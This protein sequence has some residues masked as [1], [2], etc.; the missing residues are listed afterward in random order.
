MRKIKQKKEE[1]LQNY[2]NYL[3][4]LKNKDDENDQ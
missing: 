2:N 4:T 3:N 1:A